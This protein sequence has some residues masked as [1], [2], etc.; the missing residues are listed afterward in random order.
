MPPIKNLAKESHFLASIFSKTLILFLKLTHS[1]FAHFLQIKNL[2]LVS[3]KIETIFPIWFLKTFFKL[4]LFLSCDYRKLL[5]SLILLFSQ[6]N[7]CVVG[8]KGPVKYQSS[9]FHNQGESPFMAF[10]WIGSF[11]T[12][13]CCF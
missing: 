13:S 5:Y 4:I 9:V 7:F 10:P 12:C 8:T 11:I 3:S 6:L 1:T 2:S